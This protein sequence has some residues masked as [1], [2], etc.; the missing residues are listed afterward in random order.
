[1]EKVLSFSKELEIL[2]F[3]K[4]KPEDLIKFWKEN[5]ITLSPTDSEKE[6]NEAKKY[7][8]ELFLI[9]KDRYGI[10]ATC[11]G[12]W[13]GRRGFINHLCVRKDLRKSGLGK[14]CL[15]YVE[16]LLVK[17]FNCYRVHLFVETKNLKVLN[18]Y[19]NSGYFKREDVIMMSK[20]LRIKSG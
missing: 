11:W 1:M 13:D 3:K 12:T 10:C 15:S 4:A 8:P 6:I 19:E 7:N 16:S 5:D 17:K 20:N 9:L 18:F 2:P 14:Y